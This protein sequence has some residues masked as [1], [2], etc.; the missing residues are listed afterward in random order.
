MWKIQNWLHGLVGAAINSAAGAG[1]LIII[2]PATFSDWH[3]L[4]KV[5]LVLAV[6]G[7]FLWLKEHPLPPIDE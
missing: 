5:T 4:G 3:Q 7:A 1:V 2:D 6:T